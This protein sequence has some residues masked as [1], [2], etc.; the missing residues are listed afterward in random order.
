M[1]AIGKKKRDNKRIIKEVIVIVFLLIFVALYNFIWLNRS[2]C[3]AEGWAKV[4]CEMIKMGKIPYR[5]FYYYL[6]PINLLIDY[7]FYKF[8]FG[9]FIIYRLWR[10]VERLVIVCLV[11]YI[12]KKRFPSFYS[13]IFSF[14]ASVLSVATPFDQTGD[15]HQTAQ[16]LVILLVINF[17]KYIE[18]KDKKENQYLFFCGIIGGLLFGIMQ[19]YC[20]AATIVFFVFYVFTSVFAKKKFWKIVFVIFGSLIPLLLLFTYLF[21]SKSF[22]QFVYQVFLDSDSKGTIFD[23]LF[24][25]QIRIV[26][27]RVPACLA[28]ILLVFR[29]MFDYFLK[30]EIAQRIKWGCVSSAMF[31]FG[32][33]YGYGLKQYF[34]P[35]FPWLLVLFTILFI[36]CL[37]FIDIGKVLFIIAIMLSLVLFLLNPG[38]IVGIFGEDYVFTFIT[39]E[40]TT[41]IY[42]YMIV[43]VLQGL[44][45]VFINR[46]EIDYIGETVVSGAL[47]LGYACAMGAGLGAISP[48]T[49]ILFFIAIVFIKPEL[50][51][52]SVSLQQ[53]SKLARFKMALLSLVFLLVFLI[54]F[55]QK[56]CH[57]YIWYGYESDSFWNNT[58]KSSIP[59][60]KGFRLSQNDIEK[61]DK[62]SEIIYNY[63]NEDTVIWG[64]PYVKIYNVFMNNYNTDC[65]VPVLFYDVCAS[66]MVREDARILAEKKPDIVVWLDCD[67]CLELHENLFNN[68]EEL[69]QREIINWFADLKEDNYTLIAQVDNLFVYKL[70]D[71]VP[72]T[73]TYIKDEKAVN[74]TAQKR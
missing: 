69:V 57:P 47:A 4:Y 50:F 42:I 17:I 20:V 18:N 10:L 34:F 68:G 36:F 71:E 29:K 46:N 60:L 40:I 31:L 41:L 13:A 54:C 55:T 30:G 61:Y 70:N 51:T 19:S 37:R 23:I 16:L 12:M 38:N 8:S 9:Y 6:P 43:R 39:S 14:L 52:Y 28:I 58:E 59:A 44:I 21:I 22:T 11:Y 5:D 72:V 1:G 74:Y 56:L 62:I 27:T 73:K 64:Y 2:F 26:I 63:Q 67:D 53:E 49:Q 7:F 48:S 3:M 15:Y 65:F 33:Q 25:S 32:M 66:D 24:G 45:V 35:L